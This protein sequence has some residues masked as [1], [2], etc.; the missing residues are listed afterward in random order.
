MIIRR[1]KK[2][3]LWS[4]NR[5]PY[6]SPVGP[7]P[8]PFSVSY[9]AAVDSSG[10]SSHRKWPQRRIVLTRAS[11]HSFRQCASSLL[12]KAMSFSGQTKAAGSLQRLRSDRSRASQ[13]PTAD[14]RSRIN[15]WRIDYNQNRPHTSLGGLTPEAFAALINTARKFA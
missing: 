12:R 9:N 11:G 13:S 3:S 14:T 10:A 4:G 1:E 8:N 2:G 15:A 6:P 7:A 5:A